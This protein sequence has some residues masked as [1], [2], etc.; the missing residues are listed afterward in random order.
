MAFRCSLAR[1]TDT[2]EV[3]FEVELLGDPGEYDALVMYA[4]DLL[5]RTDA[6]FHVEG[7]G[8]NDWRMDVW[9]DL[10]VFMVQFPEL[11]QSIAER[12]EFE[13][14]M[15]SQGVERSLFFY[16]GTDGVLIRCVSRTDWV[17]DPDVEVI[18]FSDLTSMLARLAVDFVESVRIVDASLVSSSPFDRWLEGCITRGDDC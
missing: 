6:R 1:P 17:P 9:Y 3:D 14:N 16:P 2:S 13:L 5:G 7:F 15:Y 11:V 18:D 12:S 10:S 4:C 8:S